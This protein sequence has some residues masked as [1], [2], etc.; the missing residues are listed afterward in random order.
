MENDLAENIVLLHLLNPEPG[1]A[2]ED[3]IPDAIERDQ[4][5]NRVLS[6]QHEQ[7]IAEDLVF[8]AAYTDDALKVI[9]LCIEEKAGGDG[10]IIRTA[11]NSGDQRVLQQGLQEIAAVLEEAARQGA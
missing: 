10:M 3:L 4:Q 2:G 7:A 1:R 11:I 5:Q 9:A 6:L 8:L